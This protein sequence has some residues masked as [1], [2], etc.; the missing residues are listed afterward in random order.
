MGGGLKEGMNHLNGT[1]ALAYSRIRIFDSDFGRTNRQ[2]NVLIA[3]LESIRHMNL[4]QIS[5]LVN[6]VFPMVTTDM[7]N[8]D[9][10]KYTVEFFPLLSEL[11]I[12]TQRVPTGDTYYS[13]MIYGMAV[14]VPDLEANREFLR[15]TLGE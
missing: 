15:E 5:N 13:A 1:Q 6:A 11:Q 10:L 7:T 3:M 4:Q 2:R 8:E 12:T 9:I 14:L